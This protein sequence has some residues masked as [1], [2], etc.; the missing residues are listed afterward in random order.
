[1]SASPCRKV[2]LLSV[3]AFGI[4]ALLFLSGLLDTF[5]L[6]AYDY[7]SRHLNPRSASDQVVIVAIDQKSISALAGQGISRI[8]S[9]NV[10]YT[11]LLRARQGAGSRGCKSAETDDVIGVLSAQYL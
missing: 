8:T 4:S 1:M 10:C 11:K 7:M 9:Y 2:A 3:L 6:K 5:E